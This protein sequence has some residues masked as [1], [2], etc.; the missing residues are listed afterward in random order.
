MFLKNLLIGLFLTISPVL[1]AQQIVTGHITDADDGTPVPG[2]SIFIA[3]TT[4]GTTSGES[5]NYS[6]TVPGR[7]SFE[8]VVSHVGYQSVFHK[9]E[10]PQDAHQYHVALKTNEIEEITIKAPKN[11]RQ[12][13]VNLFWRMIL[14]E[15]PSKRGME[16]LHPEKVYFYV[17]SDKVL[18]V[19]C[20]EPIEIINHQ[21]G[22]RIR[23]MLQDFEHDYRTYETRFTGTPFF[24]ELT[25]LNAF[26]KGRWEMKRQEVYAVSINRFLRALNREQIHEEGF[27]IINRNGISNRVTPVPL[28]DILQVEQDV[29]LLNIKDNLLLLCYSEPV[30]DRMIRNIMWENISKRNVIHPI[31]VELFPQQIIVYSDGTYRGFLDIGEHNKYMG[32][33]SSK[34]PVEYP[35]TAEYAET[36]TI[37]DNKVQNYLTVNENINAQLEAFPQEKIHLHTDRDFYVP[38]EKIWFKAYLVDA[39]SHQ[40]PVYSQLVSEKLDEVTNVFNL[41]NLY[42]QYVYVELISEAETLVD[43]VMITQTD[44][45][46]FYG[47][48]PLSDTVPEGSYTLRAYTRYMENMGDDYFFKKNIRIGNLKVENGRSGGSKGSVQ[49]DFDVSFF[50][51]GGNLLEGIMCKVAFKAINRNGNPETVSGTLTDNTGAEI[52]SVETRHAGMGILAC[53]PEAGKRYYL[54]CRNEN[55]LE[56]QFELPRSNPRMYTL[57]ASLNDNNFHI[58]V[59]R[60]VQAPEI[61]C[62]LLAHCRG[63]VLYFSEWEWHNEEDGI[64]FEQEE[65]PAGV[66]QFVLFD[67]QMNPLSE[68][69]IFSKNDADTKVVFHTNKEIYEKREKIIAT[70]K[71]DSLL[72]PSLLGRVGEGLEAGEGLPSAHFSAAITDDHDIAIDESTTIL[73]SL[74]LSSELKG[75][76]EKPAYYLQDSAAM[77]LLMMTHGWRR[78]NIP[79][80]IKKNPQYPQLPFQMYQEISGQVKTLHLRNG[81]PDSEI[82][83]MMRGGGVGV[84]STDK[85][86]AFIVQEMDFP[87]STTFY[88]RALDNRGRDNVKLTVDHKAFP[89]LI[90]A[91]RSPISNIQATVAETKDE[92]GIGAFMEKAEQRAKFD[93]DIWMLQ[94]EEVAI[95]APRMKSFD[96][97]KQ[98]RLQFWA[99]SSSDQTITRNDIE[100]RLVSNVSL[101]GA[102]VAL[103]PGAKVIDGI[104]VQ[105]RGGTVGNEVRIPAPALLVI[106]GIVREDAWSISINEVESIDIFKGTS[107]VAFGIRGANGVISITTRRGKNSP[108]IEKNNYVVYNPLGYQKPVEFYAPK[109][110]TL[111]AKRSVIPDYRTTIFWKPDIVFS[112][113]GEASFEFYTSDYRT[114]YSVVIE[115]ITADGRIVRQVEKIRVE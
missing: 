96:S 56:K 14:G 38:G 104:K 59:K 112:E 98:P 72:S 84:T 10:T 20:K 15:K 3:N 91:P 81:V 100:K 12:R 62:Y 66:I 24:E 18:K 52:T 67:K 29:A 34:V 40:Y 75:Y 115:G 99:N 60:S 44:D 27:V 97:F 77:D 63:A 26:Q 87:D 11:Y 54:K 95:T 8:I 4:V 105:L 46:M 33:L 114:T 42:S 57:A 41:Q 30:T 7:G 16:V 113:K 13:D 39:L 22:Y 108:I 102:I 48:L 17:N 107:T 111:E 49:D 90:Y 53:K 68:R 88:I 31:V 71:L 5:G 79:E 58:E 78:Y 92:P 109:Y 89:K 55:G 36:K 19:M 61:P 83:L 25:P 50:P 106:D 37:V 2:A 101:A 43:R 1:V 82:V 86:G 64:I 74:L 35:E 45:N 85:N 73:S 94:L 9:I 23:Y 32:G 51:E 103:E 47:H 28:K 21:T 93:E 80:A 6:L 69:L 76:I 110:E 70:L 65:L